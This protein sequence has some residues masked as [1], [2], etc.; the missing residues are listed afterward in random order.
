MGNKAVDARLFAAEE[1]SVRSSALVH[2]KKQAVIPPSS[3]AGRTLSARC[4][5]LGGSV[6]P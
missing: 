1:P 6:T 5:P 2:P 3:R 4:C